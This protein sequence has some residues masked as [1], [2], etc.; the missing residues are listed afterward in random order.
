MD[1]V[2]RQHD[3]LRLAGGTRGVQEGRC[4]VRAYLQRA[5]AMTRGGVGGL[6]FRAASLEF[7]HAEIRQTRLHGIE[8]YDASERGKLMAYGRNLLSLLR[9]RDEDGHGARIL[10]DVRDLRIR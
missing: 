3:A 8:A 5:L 9:G 10:Q 2:V 1:V 6:V 7:G 4:V